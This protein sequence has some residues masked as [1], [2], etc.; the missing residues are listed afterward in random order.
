M[1]RSSAPANIPITSYND[2]DD[3]YDW[4]KSSPLKQM[5]NNII[6]KPM[7]NQKDD[8]VPL[9]IV[10]DNKNYTNNLFDNGSSETA[11]IIPMYPSNSNE[12]MN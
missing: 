1:F 10:T 11:K 12:V 6:Q 8:L 9:N 5:Q 3:F 4:S 7:Y 2:I